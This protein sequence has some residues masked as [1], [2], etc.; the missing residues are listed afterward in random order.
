MRQVGLGGVECQRETGFGWWG[1]PKEGETVFGWW[2]Q[3]ETGFLGGGECQK[4]ETRGGI[5]SAK[6]ETG[7][8]VVFF[9]LM[10]RY[11]K[12]EGRLRI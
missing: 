7:F 1:V 9:P 5:G 8:G 6:K 11:A 3:S 2:S 10:R 12:R 4:G